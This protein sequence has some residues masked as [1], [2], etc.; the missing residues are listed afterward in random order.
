MNYTKVIG[1]KKIHEM[2]ALV[3]PLFMWLSYICFRYLFCYSFAG[4]TDW[5]WL[6]VWNVASFKRT[7]KTYK[8]PLSLLKFI[9]LSNS[10]LLEV[11]WN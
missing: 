5:T 11:V 6:K 4:L 8:T 7:K 9:S 1:K 3:H 10:Y 2:F